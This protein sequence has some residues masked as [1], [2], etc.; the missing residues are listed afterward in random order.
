MTTLSSTVANQIVP[1]LLAMRPLSAQRPRPIL[2]ELANQYSIEG[3]NTNTKRLNRW[4]DHGPATAG[5]EGTTFSTLTTM[6]MQTAVDLTPVEAAMMLAFVTDEAVEKLGLGFANALELFQSNNVDAILA[7]CE[8]FADSILNGIEE[9]R[10][11]DLAALFT[12][13]TNTVGALT[14]DMSLTILEQA[15][16]TADTLE[17][18]HTDRVCVLGPR[19]ISDL[20][21]ELQVSS[22]GVQGVLWGNQ[23][24]PMVGEQPAGLVGEIWVPMYQLSQSVVPTSGTVPGTGGHV[25]ALLLRGQGNPEDIGGSGQTGALQYVEGRRPTFAT[26]FKLRDRGLDLLGNCKYAVALRAQ[27]AIVGVLYDDA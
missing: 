11:R 24:A 19:G 5:T 20:R 18:V 10:E 23:R 1:R 3:L 16:F 2:T 15:I 9:K 7:A 26:D 13:A 12:S 25:G 4:A 22:G 14:G 27:D 6:S 17:Q 8:P 21:K